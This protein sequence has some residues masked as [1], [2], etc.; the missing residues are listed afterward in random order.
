MCVDGGFNLTK[1]TTVRRE[2]LQTIS[3][4]KRRKRAKDKDLMTSDV[5]KERT[6][7]I[8]WNNNEG[9]LMF[10]IKSRHSLSTWL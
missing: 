3:D 9:V 8:H 2:L 10:K 4:E 7:G 1:F 5:T 6:L